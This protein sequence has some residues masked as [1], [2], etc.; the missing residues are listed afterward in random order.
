M[1]REEDQRSAGLHWELV[2]AAVH[3]PFASGNPAAQ[4]AATLRGVI[5][6][7]G[8]SWG[9]VVGILVP[10]VEDQADYSDDRTVHPGA[11]AGALDWASRGSLV[12][13]APVK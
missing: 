2:V 3:I 9:V 7:E 10:G 8:D 4:N 13:W 11:V 6:L 5:R 1:T 12:G